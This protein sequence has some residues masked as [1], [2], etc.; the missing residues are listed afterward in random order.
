MSIVVEGTKTWTKKAKSDDIGELN[1]E[2]AK[3]IAS[4]SVIETSDVTGEMSLAQKIDRGK[5]HR[6][7]LHRNVGGVDCMGYVE[8]PNYINN[9]PYFLQYGKPQWV[10]DY[11]VNILKE[12]RRVETSY[13]A[14]RAGDGEIKMDGMASE[15]VCHPFSIEETVNGVPDIVLKARRKGI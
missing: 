5:W 15:T 9:A 6:V 12:S 7:V 13:N 14:R 2:I 4:N 8:I 3:D 1:K 10:P 11:A